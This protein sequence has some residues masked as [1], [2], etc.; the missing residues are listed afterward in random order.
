MFI[1]YHGGSL[2]Q[3]NKL[4]LRNYS[5][6]TIKAY[7]FCI[8]L[9]LKYKKINLD[10]LDEENIKDF[11][12]LLKEKNKSSQTINLYL[13]S[14]KFFYSQILKIYKKID[15][16]F[17]KRNKNLPIVLSREEIKKIKSPFD[18]I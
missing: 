8:E 10:K 14:I 1:L 7:L 4:K 17:A 18:T 5:P 3:D 13:N 15:I 2:K 11:L 12:L 6:K 16:K 9:Y